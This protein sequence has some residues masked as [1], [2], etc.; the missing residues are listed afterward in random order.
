MTAVP[1]PPCVTLWIGDRLGPLERACLRSIMRQGHRLAL[2]C[3]DPVAGVPEGVELRDAAGI[4]PREAIV[5]HKSGSPSLFSNRFRYELQRR[6]LGIW[7]DTD[8]YLLSPLDDPAPTLF[9]REQEGNIAIGILRLPPDSPLLAP[10]LALFEQ[11]YVPPWIGLR[12]RIAAH[13]RALLRGRVELGDLPWGVAGPRA[14]TALAARHGLAGLALPPEVFYPWSWRE[15]H[16]IFDPARSLDAWLTPQTRALHFYNY[17]LGAAKDAP[18]APGSFMAR[19]Q[20]E[21]A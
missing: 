21:G 15:A 16:W 11:P 2:Y 1:L 13:A 20:S 7:V 10:L 5:R 14:V 4:F 17:L 6:G 19:L 8:V 3:Y 18:A 9:G 12:P